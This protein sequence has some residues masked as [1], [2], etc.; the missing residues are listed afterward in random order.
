MYIKR[1]IV[2]ELSLNFDNQRYYIRQFYMLHR[3][4]LGLQ[5]GELKADD[6]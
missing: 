3:N 5:A 2:N 6:S 1:V 4:D